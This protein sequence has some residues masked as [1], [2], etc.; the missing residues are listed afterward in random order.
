M[1]YMKTILSIL[2]II[3]STYVLAQNTDIKSELA[4]A[5]SAYSSG[6]LEDARFALERSLNE[7]N[8]VIALEIRSMLPNMLGGISA[9]KTEDE[10]ISNTGGAGLFVTRTYKEMEDDPLNIELTITDHSPMIAMVNSFLS[11][12]MI[13]SMVMTDSD[14][15][16]VK[17]SGYKG[18]LQKNEGDNG[19]ISYSI[20]IPFGDSLMT[21]ET[22]GVELEEDALEMASEVPL[23]EIAKLVK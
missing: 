19:G 23:D 6:D 3:S 22:E 7:L 11:N 8:N 4:A 21:L 13:S 9:F 5:R 15:K 20:N 2:F 1:N 10:A 18:M 12:S 16:S 14:Q 17:V